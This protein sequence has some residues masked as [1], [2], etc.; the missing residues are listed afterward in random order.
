[1]SKI[2]R[3]FLGGSYLSSSL[4]QVCTRNM[5]GHIILVGTE[6]ALFVMT[7]AAENWKEPW[8][9][10]PNTL[11][12]VSSVSE[13][14]KFRNKLNKKWWWWWCKLANPPLSW[15]TLSQHPLISYVHYAFPL[16]KALLLWFYWQKWHIVHLFATKRSWK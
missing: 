10:S 5:I 15:A 6:G 8:W 14:I 9:W 2:F 12:C 13:Q 16:G 3:F 11:S 1:M 7:T 4:G